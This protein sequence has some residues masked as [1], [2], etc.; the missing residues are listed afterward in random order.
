MN[1]NLQNIYP[2]ISRI[3]RNTQLSNRSVTGSPLKRRS[4]A[5][6]EMTCK[7]S[8]ALI[9]MV[10]SKA[11]SVGHM[12]C[13]RSSR[14]VCSQKPSVSHSRMRMISEGSVAESEQSATEGI[15]PECVYLRFQ[16][17]RLS[18]YACLYSHTQDRL[19]CCRL[20]S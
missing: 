6:F 14:L 2:F 11:C 17:D 12:K 10:D 9:S 1:K 16:P 19:S 4:K 13:P 3:M 8:E 5:V 15:Q 20:Q 18:A 7:S